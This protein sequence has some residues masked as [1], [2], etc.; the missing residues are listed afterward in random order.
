[1]TWVKPELVCQVK[2]ANWTQDNRLRA[3]VFLGLRDDVRAARGRARGSRRCRPNRPGAAADA[4]RKSPLTID[5]HTLK[6]TNLKKVYYPDD[7]VHQARRP[8]LLRRASPT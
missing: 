1:M 2:Y 5:G 6:F 3:P 4:P 8:Q 7:G